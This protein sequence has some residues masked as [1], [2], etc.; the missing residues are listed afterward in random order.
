MIEIKEEKLK[1]WMEASH[2]RH[3]ARIQAI[4]DITD[5]EVT[6]ELG[7]EEPD[8]VEEDT[9]YKHLTQTDGSFY[10]LTGFTRDEFDK[11]WVYLSGPLTSPARGR[12]AKMSPR[13]VLIIILH[14]IRRYP[15]I[16]E[17]AAVFFIQTI[18]TSRH[19]CQV[20]PNYGKYIKE[21]SYRSSCCSRYTI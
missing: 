10:A 3:E 9:L 2:R 4:I 13:D 5:R 18:D 20:Y 7:I 12:K 6:E 14:Y 19:N 15:R 17:A 16:E 11:L 21:G 8:E 1:R